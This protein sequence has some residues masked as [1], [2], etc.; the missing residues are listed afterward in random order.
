MSGAVREY[1]TYFDFEI[2]Q[3][4]FPGWHAYYDRN[5]KTIDSILYL[6]T[7]TEALKGAWRNSHQY[8]VGDVVIDV[9]NALAFECIT[10]HVSAS[11]P[12]TFLEDRTT[13]PL[14]WQEINS[15][16]EGLWSTSTSSVDIGT[17]MKTFTTQTGRVYKPGAKIIVNQTSN[18]QIN[19]MWG[20][21]TSYNHGLLIMDVQTSHGLGTH[22]DW[23]ISVSGEQGAVGP[24]GIIAEA[25]LDGATYGRQMSTWVTVAVTSASTLS[26]TPA[27]GIQAHNVEDAIYEL[28]SEKVG[29]GGDEM[30]GALTTTA[31]AVGKFTATGD[32][33][34]ISNTGVPRWATRGADTSTSDY[35]LFRYNDSGAVLSG[36]PFQIKRA[37]GDAYFSYNVNVIGTLICSG[38]AT[39]ANGSFQV[40]YNATI[41]LYGDGTYL[42]LRAYGNN[43]ILIGNAGGTVQYASFLKSHSYIYSPL[44]VTGTLTASGD[45]VG[46]NIYATGSMHVASQI[47]CN[48]L[49]VTGAAAIGSSL[50]ATGYTVNVA[51]G[52]KT[53]TTGAVNANSLYQNGVG[54]WS[55]GT[56]GTTGDYFFYSYT[57]N[58][59][60]L[61]VTN[62][63]LEAAPGYRCRE[64]T[65]GALYAN[66]FNVSWNRNTNGLVE[67]WID[68]SNMGPIVNSPSDY[69]MKKDVTPLTTMWET[70]KALKP[71][72]YTQE[73]FGSLITADDVER[74]GFIAHELQETMTQSAATGYKDEPDALQSPNALTIIAALTKA[75]QEAMSRIE[76][77]EAASAA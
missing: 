54:K 7:G 69:R 55:V 20:S 13:N 22:N 42:A 49:N 31:L 28:D 65:D 51:E 43:Q 38:L 25:P 64:G 35:T 59:L 16:S 34:Y 67:L 63:G 12:V 8:Y 45:L 29:K 1:T 26:I 44:D 52:F 73:A 9:D 15:L 11:V 41:G 46:T 66:P 5:I 47:V 36:T 62:S 76:A 68:S 61:S 40:G 70:V 37:T 6:M 17:G 14:Y 74:W 27:G 71:I 77:L 32:I 39:F 21:V 72:K 24:Q 56:S 57:Y 2:P 4:D 10:D 19:Y 58:K 60:L 30:T 75:L 3:F 33:Y 18:P 50:T 48:T 53:V 23:T